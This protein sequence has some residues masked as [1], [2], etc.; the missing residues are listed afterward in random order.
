MNLPTWPFDTS[1]YTQ[2]N[3]HFV[4]TLNCKV[5]H[6]GY[7]IEEKTCTCVCFQYD[8]AEPDWPTHHINMNDE[9]WVCHPD[10]LIGGPWSAAYYDLEPRSN[11]VPNK[12]AADAPLTRE[13][14]GTISIA[15]S[16][17]AA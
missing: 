2:I 10:V 6:L 17:T 14:F 12:P 1:R 3:S 8:G 11:P 5:H 13:S 7:P 16:N 9:C 4:A 15:R